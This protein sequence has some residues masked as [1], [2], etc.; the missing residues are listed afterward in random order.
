MITFKEA[1]NEMVLNGALIKR[2]TWSGYWAWE[3]GTIMM[4]TKEGKVIDIRETR[5]VSYTIRGMLKD[6]WEIATENNCPLLASEKNYT[7]SV[8]SA[9]SALG[10]GTYIGNFSNS[11]N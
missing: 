7:C 9:A 11:S 3:N 4:H 2:T 8:A 10:G 5:D 6:D 1:F